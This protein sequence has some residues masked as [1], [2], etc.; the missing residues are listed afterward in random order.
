[1]EDDDA[2]EPRPPFSSFCQGPEECP[3]GPVY[4]FVVLLRLLPGEGRRDDTNAGGDVIAPYVRDGVE[5]V[6]DVFCADRS[7][8]GEEEGFLVE[9]PGAKT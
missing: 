7:G 6:E 3:G 5:V 2:T 9:E 1:V 8:G 4:L